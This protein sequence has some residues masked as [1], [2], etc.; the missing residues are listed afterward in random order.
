VHGPRH[1]GPIT[2][3]TALESAVEIGRVDD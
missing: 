2:T 3:A 1:D